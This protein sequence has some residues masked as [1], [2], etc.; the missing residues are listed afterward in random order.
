MQTPQESKQDSTLEETIG[1]FEDRRD[2]WKRNG[3]YHEG[4][5]TDAVIVVKDSEVEIHDLSPQ[6]AFPMNEYL[7]KLE[8]KGIK[9]TARERYHYCG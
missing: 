7:K 2:M 9:L 1:L 6:K 8:E 4:A 3:I 5:K